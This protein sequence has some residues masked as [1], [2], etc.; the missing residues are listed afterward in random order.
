MKATIS[1]KTK[2]NKQTK[3]NKKTTVVENIAHHFRTHTGVK[4]SGPKCSISAQSASADLSV[5]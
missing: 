4:N 3:Q 5:L 2:Q 1:L